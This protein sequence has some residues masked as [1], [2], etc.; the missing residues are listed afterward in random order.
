VYSVEAD[1]DTVLEIEALP[2]E[3]LAAFAEVMALLECR[4]TG[5]DD[6]RT[7]SG[8]EPTE[9]TSESNR[10]TLPVIGHA[11]AFG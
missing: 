7:T 9:R 1:S 10:I 8:S 3:A 5:P 2:G 6:V 4:R 11:G